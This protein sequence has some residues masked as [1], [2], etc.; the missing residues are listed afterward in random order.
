[1]TIPIKIISKKEYESKNTLPEQEVVWD[2][3]A[4]PWKT[5]VVKKI[6]IVEEFLKGK[7]GKVV[8]LGCGTGR[9][10]LKEKGLKYYG[11]DFSK[12]QL[13][14]AKK[15]V[16]GEKIDV[17]LFCSRIDKLDKKVFK[18]EMF[19][20]G[21]FIST[22]HCLESSKEREK[23]LKEFYRILKKGGEGLISVWDSTDKRFDCVGNNGDV[24]MDWRE[25]GKSHMRYY[26]LY[27]REELLG[28]LS[29][30]GF[31]IVEVGGSDGGGGFGG[32]CVDRFGRKNLVVRVVK[33]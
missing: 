11:V 10:M 20:Y 27:G 31:N 9:N 12:G 24:Y 32:L 2:D 25:D 16:D 17:E 28:L 15:Y 6:P 30:V 4:E 19:D 5:Y 29:S 13:V 3:I 22:L 7:K 14:H 23:S 18:D 21:L 8:D 33:K 26:Y 1:M